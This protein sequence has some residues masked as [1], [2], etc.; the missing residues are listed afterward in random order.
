MNILYIAYSCEPNS[1]SEDKIG[2]NIPL[3][4]SKYHNVTVVTKQEHKEVIEEYL[5]KND[6]HNVKFY[7]VDINKIYKKLFKGAMYSIR[8]NIWH[9]NAYPLVKEICSTEKVDVIHQ[10]TPI[11]FR[12][13]GQY[14]DIENVKFVCGPLGGGEQLPIE[15]KKY[16]KNNKAVEWCR[17][18]LNKRSKRKHKKNATFKKCNYVLF[19]NRE[20]QEYLSELVDD[21]PC[22]LCAETAISEEDILDV[23]KQH[24]NKRFTMLVAGRLVYRK[25]HS[26]LFDSL[27]LLSKDI[28]YECR[29]VGEGPMENKLKD[30]VRHMN[31]SDKVVF[32]GSVPFEKMS[33]EYKN[34]DVFIMPSIRETSGA[35]L[36]ES[37]AHGLPVITIN[38]FGGRMIISDDWGYLFDGSSLNEY[39]TNLKDILL[40]CMNNRDELMIKSQR[41]ADVAKN[42]V[43]S[44]RME[45]YNS[46]Y[47]EITNK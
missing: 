21:V 31:L 37:V 34:A 2:W 40:H 28:D 18:F 5:K 38:K 22:S 44:K 45:Y 8:L 15:F 4:C 39:K 27:V 17:D 11:E 9:K 13:I 16:V 43:W 32:V 23:K 35:V 47:D 33:E 3:E 12:S 10:I 14:Y 19:A 36:Y 7:F 24:T 1:G 41:L 29:V 25:G 42:N 6:I 20:T 46:I 30:K 26:F